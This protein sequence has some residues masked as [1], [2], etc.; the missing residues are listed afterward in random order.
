MKNQVVFCCIA[1]LFLTLKLTA[2][3]NFEKGYFIYDN[4]AKETCLIKNLDWKDNP[5]SIMY[6]LTETDEIKSVSIENIKEFAVDGSAKFIKAKVSIDRSNTQ[7]DKLSNKRM[8]E[9]IQ[10]T[11]FLKVLIEGNANLYFYMDGNLKRF[12]FKT[13]SKD[14]EQLVFKNYINKNGVIAENIDFKNQ[15]FNTLKCATIEP[16]EVEKLN[17]EENDLYNL[18]LKYNSCDGGTIAY[19]TNKEKK[20]LLN[21]TLKAGTNY[22]S[23]DVKNY[24]TPERSIGFD[25]E[26]GLWFGLELEALLPFNNNKWAL[27]IESAYQTYKSNKTKINP[28]ALT[29]LIVNEA[30]ITYSTFELS[31]GARH[32]FFLNPKSKLFVNA[33]YTLV[34]TGN[35]VVDYKIDYVSDLKIEKASAKSIGFGYKY[36]D[37]WGLEL[38]YGFPRN[39]LL[40]YKTHE[41]TYNNLS[42]IFGYTIF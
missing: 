10:E 1:L 34:F 22:A 35:S 26:F 40:N 36:A 5:T 19:T 6:K 13:N 18:F 15:I 12:F 2:Q 7:V 16:K 32:Y 27:L 9:F 17:Y 25:N 37:T 42:L 31:L 4:D 39:V 21:F 20:D 29:H 30:D 41:S 33:A 24:T 11:L 38:R 28:D 14:I 23:L 3:N 8:P